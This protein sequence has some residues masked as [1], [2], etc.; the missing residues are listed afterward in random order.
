MNL[1]QFKKRAKKIPDAPGVYFFLGPPKPWRRG[2]GKR[3]EVLYIGKAASLHDRVRSY[4]VE[5]IAEVRSPLVAK[6]VQNTKSIDWRRTD[7]VL[8]ALIL[9]ASLIK[10][11][12]PKGNTDAKDDKSWNYVVITK[13]DFPR[14]LLVRGKELAKQNNSEGG[15]RARRRENLSKFS[16][17]NL[18][19]PR[20]VG[21]A[22]PLHT[23]GPFPHGL[24]LKEALKIVRKIFPY[25]DSCEPQTEKPCFNRQIGLCPGV[26][27]G[28]I[29][30]I[31]YRK[32][33]RRITLLFQGK[34]SELVHSLTRDMKRAAREER[35]EEA[36]VL[37]R[38]LFALKHIQDVSLIKEEHR[39]FGAGLTKSRIEAYDVAHLGGTSTVGVMTVVEE[40][41]AKRSEYRKF[42]INAAKKGDDAGALREILSR[43]LGH[44]E[45]PLPKLIVVDGAVAQINAAQRVLEHYSISIPVVGVVK[46]ERHRP[47]EIKGLP[48]LSSD[49]SRAMSRDILLANSEAHRFAIQYHRK[50]SRRERGI[51]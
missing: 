15:F 8:E 25:R 5:D 28:E 50:R 20:G 18:R 45:W 4:F 51:L 41:E 34:K 1:E 39:S 13:E 26:C 11:Y 32:V 35:F 17:E 44:D 19:T 23:F 27:S 6:V 42:R 22:K 10:Q 12:K 33:I 3:R 24:Q 37:R 29:S 30:K 40:G 38:Q 47:R 31:N 21:F 46:D 7:S 9:E 14:V 43:R 49:L 36:A 48:R 16:A 2:L